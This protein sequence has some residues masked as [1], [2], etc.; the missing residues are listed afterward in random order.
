MANLPL[1]RPVGPIIGL[2]LAELVFTVAS[3]HK[4]S[5]G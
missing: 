5:V 4:T 2:S 3:E 1:C